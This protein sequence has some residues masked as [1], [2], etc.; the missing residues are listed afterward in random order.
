ML[1]LGRR[2]EE[3]IEICVHI[4]RV[5]PGNVKSFLGVLFRF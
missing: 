2:A 1:K 4:I 5:N 3:L